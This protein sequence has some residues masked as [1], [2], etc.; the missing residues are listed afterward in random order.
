MAGPSYFKAY[1]IT[2]DILNGQFSVGRNEYFLEY[3]I[4]WP[5]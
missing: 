3:S 5:P 2:E 4:I 1:A